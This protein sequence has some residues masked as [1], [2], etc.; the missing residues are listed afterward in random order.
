[1]YRKRYSPQAGLRQG[2]EGVKGLTDKGQFQ[3]NT[4]LMGPQRGHTDIQHNFVKKYL[5]LSK[6]RFIALCKE[7]II[8]SKRLAIDLSGIALRQWYHF[9]CI[10]I[11]P[12]KDFSINGRVRT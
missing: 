9:Y 6:D 7:V 12:F 10:R 11:Y 1:M 8:I 4:G 3:Y 2:S 5:N